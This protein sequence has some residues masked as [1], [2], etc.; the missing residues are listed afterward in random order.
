[1][2]AI[3]AVVQERDASLA[4]EALRKRKF[5]VKRIA[6]TGRF[7]RWGNVTLLIGVDEQRVEEAV[8]L[9]QERCR[10]RRRVEAMPSVV[11]GEF[12]MPGYC[13]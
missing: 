9:L 2:K 12:L 5:D 4:I 7:W 13:F 3:L 11:K 6:S 10:R 8:D 1:M